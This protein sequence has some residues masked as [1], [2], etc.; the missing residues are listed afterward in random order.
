MVKGFSMTLVSTYKT[1]PLLFM[2]PSNQHLYCTKRRSIKRHY[3]VI[4]HVNDLFLKAGTQTQRL[5]LN[6]GVGLTMKRRNS[7]LDCNQGFVH[8]THHR[9][10]A[11]SFTNKYTSLHTQT[12]VCSNG[13]LNLHV[14]LVNIE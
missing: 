6:K 9:K 12:P 1:Q 10:E 13:G 4:S 14:L 2:F 5:D 7:L 3:S 11:Q 8:G